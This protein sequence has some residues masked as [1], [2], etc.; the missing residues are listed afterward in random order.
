MQLTEQGHASQHLHDHLRRPSS[1]CYRVQLQLLHALTLHE[2]QDQEQAA[3]PAQL[4]SCE[5]VSQ[6]RQGVRL[7]AQA[8][9]SL[10]NGRSSMTPY[11][12]PC[13]AKQEENLM[14]DKLQTLNNVLQLSAIEVSGVVCSQSLWVQVVLCLC[15]ALSCGVGPCQ[16]YY[17]HK[18]TVTTRAAGFEP[19]LFNTL[20]HCLD[21][22][23]C[24]QSHILTC[25]SIPS[26]CKRCSRLML[27][28]ASGSKASLGLSEA[29]VQCSSCNRNRPRDHHDMS[30][31]FSRYM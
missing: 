28:K 12:R 19:L 10:H 22:L 17:D 15:D 18:G 20:L 11:S 16:R 25:M 7:V 3:S 26:D 23:C 21:E 29:Q 4:Q 31:V 1:S 30:P 14:Q 13:G 5:G 6:W 24:Q 2:A 8:P 27:P 9:G